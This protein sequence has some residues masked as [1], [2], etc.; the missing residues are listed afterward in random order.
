MSKTYSQTENCRPSFRNDFI[1]T[2]FLIF[3]NF[4]VS[5]QIC[6]KFCT[7]MLLCSDWLW[8]DVTV[9]SSLISRTQFC[10]NA[11]QRICCHGN[12]KHF[13]PI[14]FC[15]EVQLIF[16]ENTS[17]FGED[18]FRINV[19]I[20]SLLIWMVQ[21][22]RSVVSNIFCHGNMNNP[23]LIKFCTIE[24]L[25]ISNKI[26]KLWWDWL[27]NY[28]TVT[29][30]LFLMTRSFQSSL[31]SQCVAMTTTRKS[32]LKLLLFNS[33]YIFYRGAEHPHPPTGRRGL[34][35]CHFSSLRSWL[36]AQHSVMNWLSR[37]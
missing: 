31:P 15:T 11:H 30:W 29:S 26:T 24:Q 27:R 20:T 6:L 7:E 33:F 10:L 22:H 18:W 37:Q 36:L 4:F 32:I 19:T 28:V 14:K 12:I 9:T 5:C 13:L 25:S 8:N 35:K 34:K 2:S 21:F 17:K 3:C 16:S 23:I 1:M